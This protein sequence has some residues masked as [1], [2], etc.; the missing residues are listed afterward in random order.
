[1]AFGRG[2]WFSGVTLWL[3]WMILVA[4]AVIVSGVLV[5]WG[6]RLGLV[7]F[8][9]RTCMCILALVAVI[10]TASMMAIVGDGAR[11]RRRC[12]TIAGGCLGRRR[13]GDSFFL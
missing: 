11:L 7:R 1:M 9:V 10:F 6:C 4:V 3:G 5:T 13:I 12:D 2:R 8:L